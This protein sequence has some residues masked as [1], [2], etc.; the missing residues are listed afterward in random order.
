MLLFVMRAAIY[1][2]VSKRD[3]SQDTENQAVVLRD[4]CR[5]MKW[6][7]VLEYADNESAKSG[8]RDAFQEMLTAA[9]QRKFDCVVVWALDRLTREGVAETFIYIKRLLGHGVQFISFTEE[10]FRTTGAAGELMIAIAAWIAKQERIRIS[11]RTRAGLDKAR[12]K[13]VRL[14]RP[15][16]V[17]D[18]QRVADMHLRKMSLSVIA[19]KSGLS[20][21]TVARIVAR[22][23]KVAV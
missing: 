6:P 11:E 16:R 23:R 7:L 14:G 19:A 3:K 9:A 1:S 20:K 22:L 17:Y 21:T 2:R 15:P 18:R 13:G 8:E 12:A 4:Y 5:S 10:H